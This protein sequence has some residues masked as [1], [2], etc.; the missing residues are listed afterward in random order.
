VAPITAS[1]HSTYQPISTNSPS[2][3]T[4]AST[5]STPSVLCSASLAMSPPPHTPICTP[6]NHEPLHLVGVC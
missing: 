6:K 2:A 5:P 1:A 4:V 3:S